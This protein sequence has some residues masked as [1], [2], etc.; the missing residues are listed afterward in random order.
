[1]KKILYLFLILSTYFSCSSPKEPASEKTT[2][3]VHLDPRTISIN[4]LFNRIEVIPIETSEN[5]FMKRMSKMMELDGKYYIL[6]NELAV[7]FEFDENGKYLFKIDK[8]GDGPGEYYLIYDFAIDTLQKRIKMLSPMGSI[9]YYDMQGNFIDRIRLPWG[10]QQSMAALNNRNLAIWSLSSFSDGKYIC[11]FDEDSMQPHN[12]FWTDAEE[13]FISNKKSFDVFYQYDGNTYFYTEYA[14]DVFL[15]TKE[16]TELVY[17]WNFYEN[18]LNLSP[19][20]ETIKENPDKFNFLVDNQDVPYRFC[21]QFQNDRYYYT[22][23]YTYIIN[24]RRNVFYSKDKNNAIVF[25]KTKE[26]IVLSKPLVFND[27][28]MI[29]SATYEDI[30]NY[31]EVLSQEEFSKIADRIED[32][33]PFLVKFY[34]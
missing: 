7:L 10:G 17:T 2:L 3:N 16:G 18:N 32:D 11:I 1:M 20:L 24:R 22:Q 4:D 12:S 26:N 23:L 21:S 29:C 8:N 33:N 14:N 9:H 6:D 25:D 27:D 19:Y 15:L 13:N 34:F 28:Y 31:K 30:K 5:C